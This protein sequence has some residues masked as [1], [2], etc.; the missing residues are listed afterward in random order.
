MFVEIVWDWIFMY[1]LSNLSTRKC[2][3]TDDGHLVLIQETR[4]QEQERRA[5]FLKKDTSQH[6]SRWNNAT[7][8]LTIYSAVIYSAVSASYDIECVLRWG[9]WDCSHLSRSPYQQLYHWPQEL[10]HT[11]L[12][13]AHCIRLWYHT[14]SVDDM[15]ICPFRKRI[16]VQAIYV[17]VCSRLPTAHQI[18][19]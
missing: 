10:M 8:L 18:I 4:K 16:Q 13:M 7:T 11:L 12:F 3:M 19:K 2:K 9:F 6:C 17:I 5:V 15:T 1:H 14:R